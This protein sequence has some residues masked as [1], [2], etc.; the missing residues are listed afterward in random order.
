[1]AKIHNSSPSRRTRCLETLPPILILHLQQ[2][3]RLLVS[4]FHPLFG[5]FLLISIHQ[6]HLGA[7]TTL[8]LITQSPL[9]G[10]ARLE[11][12]VEVE[13]GGHLPLARVA[14]HSVRRLHLNQLRQTQ[15]C[16]AKQIPLGARSGLVQHLVTSH[17]R[18]R[19]DHRLVCLQRNCL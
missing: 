2:G 7:I 14:E 4:L 1:L 13:V 9:L 10:L 8:R 3:A 6:G 19:S 16:S 5:I 18:A 11:V 17:Q 15:A 12:E